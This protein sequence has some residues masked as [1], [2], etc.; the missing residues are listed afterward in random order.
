MVAHRLLDG[1]TELDISAAFEV[2][3]LASRIM[4][5]TERM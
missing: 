1:V 5:E 4:L 2:I 3:R